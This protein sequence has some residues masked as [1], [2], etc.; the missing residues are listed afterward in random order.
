[1]ESRFSYSYSPWEF[2]RAGWFGL[3]TIL[4]VS[5]LASSQAL[6]K[7][8]EVDRKS[9]ERYFDLLPLR[10]E[11]NQGQS[12]SDAK[13][14]AEGRGFSALFR[15]NE[16]DLLLTRRSGAEDV[17][18]VTLPNTSKNAAISAETRLP[19]TVN[20]F[21]GNDPK[22]WQTALPTFKCLR[23]AGVYDGIDL[24][25]YG[26][27]G[28]LE[29]DFQLS[30]GTDPGPILMRF[31]G[32]ENVRLDPNGNLIVTGKWGRISFQ[33][34]VIYQ[35]TDNGGK[36]IV[37]GSFEIASKNTIGFSV[38]NYDRTRPLIIDPILNYS[39]YIGPFAEATSIAVDQNGEAYVLGLANKNFPT[40]P[41]SYQPVAATTT[42]A[43]GPF[44]AKFNATGT[45]LLYA[46]Y[47]T[48]NG[49]DYGDGLALDSNGDAFVVGT[50]SSTNFPITQGALQT[51]NN[52]SQTIG[53]VT[54]LNS[55]G[56]SL[57][58]STYLGGSTSTSVNRIALD[59]AGNAYLTG[60]TQDTNFPTT[61]GAY[62]TTAPT[63]ANAGSSSAF[64]SKLNST[65]TALVYSTYLGGSQTDSAF[66]IA[67]DSAG[68]AFV[69]G[70]T[71]SNDFPVTAGAFQTVREVTNT[72]AGF[73]AKVNTSGS[74]LVYSTYLSGQSFDSLLAIAVDSSGNA[75]ATGGTTSPDFPITPGAF[76][77]TIGYTSFDYPQTNAFVS[78]L[79]GAGTSLLYS[80]FLGGSLSLG[81]YADEGDAAHAISVDGQGY[82]Y[83]TGAACT[84][85]FPVTIGAFEPQNLDGE[86]SAECTAF[87]TKMN[88]V[89]NAPLLYSTFLGGTGQQFPDDISAG[90]GA[91][92]LALDQSGNVYLAGYTGSV[93]FPTTA[94]VVETA[95]ISYLPEAFVS[96]FNGSE[97]KTLPIPT[98]TITSNISPVLFGQPVTFT[99]TVQ[100]ANGS[101]TPTGYVGFNFLEPEVS[102]D[103]GTGIGYGPWT[104]VALDGSGAATFTTSSLEALQTPVNAFYLG[105]A[106]NAPASA[107]MTQAVKDLPTVTTVTSNANDVLYATPIVFTA[108]VLD[109][110]GNPAE[111]FVFFELGNIVY[112]E[113]NLDSAG[114]AMWT[115]GTGGP[116]LP[117]GTDTVAVDFF[118]AVGYQNSIGTLA[119]TFTPLGT[120][121]APTFAPPAGTYSTDQSV[122]LADSNSD[123]VIYYTIDGSVPVVGT[124]PNSASGMT[125]HV[126]SSETINALATAPGYMASNVVTATYTINLPAPDFSLSL[127]P[128]SIVVTAGSSGLTTVN[129][130]GLNGFTQAVSLSC[131]GLP[132]GVT[133]LF[134]P[135]APLANS[136]ST[137]TI[138]ASTSAAMG[139]S[140]V[141]LHLR[142]AAGAAMFGCFWI[143]RQ[144]IG[145]LV[146]LLCALSLV[147]ISGCGG[148]SGQ[149]SSP[150]S[151]SSTVTVTGTSDNLKRSVSLTLTVAQ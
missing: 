55:T 112:A 125:I 70:N 136:P 34:P 60:S 44:V 17:L 100:S 57:V 2:F 15:Q 38:G 40:T 16:A 130:N 63:K 89:P 102:D 5:P 75:Y 131:S 36:E 30:P 27:Q 113:V 82:A 45:S 146:T 145:R 105:D 121:P 83:L 62:K 116:P 18:R 47:L 68:E 10:F 14:L 95:F 19:G 110:N 78:K 61:Q 9:I 134:S 120:A 94:G 79:N 141:M 88:P 51:T 52:A 84:G 144:R 43:G 23:Y 148:G 117:E 39:T 73:V 56:S 111:G 28:R 97:M 151:N 74:G 122:T 137:L 25:Y 22:K 37:A 139:A 109:D 54:E 138:A 29:F 90:D 76:Q 106:N 69:G 98:V 101:N 81:V 48:G 86:A 142:L 150:H 4:V 41:G 72:Q 143:R 96:E 71:T 11:P 53:F 46:T 126:T 119:E 6:T 93:D 64:I 32:A 33:K 149:T 135:A 12:S 50:T 103:L 1:M 123:A 59:T 127:T 115:N 124:S 132:V 108:T 77:S 13:F 118:P 26:S 129:V 104:T 35:P 42:A 107:T 99:A 66:A 85:D 58:Y 91:F 133:C 80:T 3:L 24:V 92:G 147:A 21:N 20:Y 31:D 128:S 87:L 65:G 49:L 140:P 7:A 67:V 8:S 114:Q